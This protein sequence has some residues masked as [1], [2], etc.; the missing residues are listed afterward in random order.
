LPPTEEGAL[1]DPALEV[2]AGQMEAHPPLQLTL[3][4]ESLVL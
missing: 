4:A 3:L 2:S 1:T